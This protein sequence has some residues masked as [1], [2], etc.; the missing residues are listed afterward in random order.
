MSTYLLFIVLSQQLTL[1]TLNCDS[2]RWIKGGIQLTNSQNSTNDGRW[3]LVF[4]QAQ[5]D[6]PQE[7]FRIRS[8]DAKDY[9]DTGFVIT[10]YD[11]GSIPF[12]KIKAEYEKRTDSLTKLYRESIKKIFVSRVIA[13]GD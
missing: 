8:T 4:E 7:Q 10:V 6:P 12:D 13:I 1:K 11:N 9:F 5:A 3:Y 2:S